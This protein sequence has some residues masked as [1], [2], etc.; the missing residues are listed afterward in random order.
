MKL[1]L[2][3]LFAGSVAQPQSAPRVF[4]VNKAADSVSVINAATLRVEHTIP[5]G[6]NPH[7]LAVSPNGQKLYVPNV[8]ENSI[9]VIDLQSHSQTKKITH[10]DF[11][12]PH[13]VDFTPDSRRA[14]VTSERSR[15][16]FVLDAT[17]DQVLRVVDTD[18]DGTHMV[19][20]NKA[21]TQAYLTNRES[22]TV[23]IMDLNTYR[24]VANIRVGRGAEGFAVSPD[25]K[26]I[27]I[28][29]RSEGTIS[30]V[31]VTARSV[32]ATFSTGGTPNRIAFTPDGKHVLVGDSGNLD[33]YDAQKRTKIQ[34]VSM[35]SNP[36]GIVSAS[37]GKHIYVAAGGVQVVDTQTWKVTNRTTVGAGPDG[38]TYR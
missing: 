27:W 23:S 37:D 15:K 5:V 26:Q 36:G 7:E 34:S 32:V 29:N 25:D 30:V 19:T 33:V 12:S 20:V 16:I 11:N 3:M 31:D 21:G 4:V 2:A 28:G 1:L 24:I 35:G 22:N 17:T 6:R 13:G 9:S 10:P 8:A 38:I 18:Q 14:V